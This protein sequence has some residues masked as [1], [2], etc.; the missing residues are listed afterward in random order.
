MPFGLVVKKASKTCVILS[1]GMPWPASLSAPR[2]QHPSKRFS[3]FFLQLDN[4][5][6]AVSYGRALTGAVWYKDIVRVEY[7]YAF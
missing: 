3:F 5:S 1:A 6:F 2:A 7:R 4:H